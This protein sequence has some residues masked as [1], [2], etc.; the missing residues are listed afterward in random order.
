MHKGFT[1]QKYDLDLETFG[2]VALV[3]EPIKYCTNNPALGSESGHCEEIQPKQMTSDFFYFDGGSLKLKNYVDMKLLGGPRHMIKLGTSGGCF[4]YYKVFIFPSFDLNVDISLV[5]K[6]PNNR[7]LEHL[8]MPTSSLINNG[9]NPLFKMDIFDNV[10]C[11]IRDECRLDK[12]ACQNYDTDLSKKVAIDLWDVISSSIHF[13][14]ARIVSGPKIELAKNSSEEAGLAEMAKRWYLQDESGNWLK[15]APQSPLCTITIQLDWYMYQAI[16]LIDNINKQETLFIEYVSI[17]GAFQNVLLADAD[18]SFNRNFDGNLLA[19]RNRTSIRSLFYDDVE[20]QDVDD[21]PAI[22]VIDQSCQSYFDCVIIDKLLINQTFEACKDGEALLTMNS[23]LFVVDGDRQINSRSVRYEVLQSRSFELF[24]SAISCTAALSPGQHEFT[25]KAVQ[26]NRIDRT[27]YLT[28]AVTIAEPVVNWTSIVTTPVKSA[29]FEILG[30]PSFVMNT[31]D[32]SA[33]KLDISPPADGQEVI[34]ISKTP[35]FTFTDRFEL[36]YTGRRNFLLSNSIDLVVQI[37]LVENDAVIAREDS[38][39]LGIF[40]IED[41]TATTTETPK[42]DSFTA[43]EYATEMLNECSTPA[44]TCEPCAPIE[45]SSTAA[46]SSV[47]TSMASSKEDKSRN[48]DLFKILMSCLAALFFVT[49]IVFIILWSRA[50][51][52]ANEKIAPIGKQVLEI[53]ENEDQGESKSLPSESELTDSESI[54][55]SEYAQPKIVWVPADTK[56]ED[57]VY[58]TLEDHQVI[59]KNFIKPGRIVSHREV[60]LRKNGETKHA[61]AVV[62]DIELAS[63]DMLNEINSRIQI[64]TQISKMRHENVLRYYGSW[65]ELDKLYV[66]YELAEKGNLDEHLRQCLRPENSA[67]KISNNQIKEIL[68]QIVQGLAHLHSREIIHGNLQ[69]SAIYLTQENIPKIGKVCNNQIDSNDRN[70]RRWWAPE[71]FENDGKHSCEADIWA[72]G[73][74]MWEVCSFGKTPYDDVELDQLSQ[75]VK[76]NRLDLPNGDFPDACTFMSNCWII[77]PRLR[78]DA[79]QLIELMSAE[80]EGDLYEFLV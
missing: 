62:H 72:L 52:S 10:F 35:G 23:D 68:F 26:D 8:E 50:R 28:V 48:C 54:S 43:A 74:V 53:S 38:F 27:S 47:M 31:Q 16:T 34:L 77:E 46:T 39:S 2:I 7:I 19:T 3:D 25:M 58:H 61:F 40:N 70:F 18:I 55:D 33:F 29:E 6:T 51:N 65:V 45:C 14:N 37:L 71:L 41:R 24:G 69:A 22:F 1:A 12:G 76:D 36:L 59:L 79:S 56:L 42:T 73:V 21:L 64:E 44:I 32:H 17:Q 80:Q 9:L 66:G 30:S 60:L 63:R 67:S 78:P 13:K 49:T 20:I 15:I 57:P 11:A 4:V 5:D 75:Y